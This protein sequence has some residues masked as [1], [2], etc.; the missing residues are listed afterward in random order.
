MSVEMAY[1]VLAW[2][3]KQIKSINGTG[4]QYG[5]YEYRLTY[6][7]GFASYIA[8]DRRE[9]GRRNFVYFGGVS[10]VHCFSAKEAMKLVVDEIKKKGGR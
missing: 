8:I 10:A 9:V 7:G 6:R 5:R 2:Q 3:D 4:F 1:A